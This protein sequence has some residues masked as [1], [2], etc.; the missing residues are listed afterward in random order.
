MKKYF[1]QDLVEE[2]VRWI[3]SQFIQKD[4]KKVLSDNN[5]DAES[6]RKVDAIP[7]DPKY[8]DTVQDL[9]DYV[10]LQNLQEGYATKEELK[11]IDIS[12]QLKEYQKTE[13]RGV[14]GGYASLGLDGKVPKSQLPE[15]KDTITSIGGKTGVISKED[16]VKLGIPAQDT[17]YS[18]ANGSVQGLSTND[19]STLEKTKLQNIETKAQV[20]KIETIKRNGSIISASEDKSVNIEVPTK[21]SQLS[22]D[23]GF[24]T[25]REVQEAIQQAKSFGYKF[26]QHLPEEGEDN[27]IYAVQAEKGEGQNL[28]KEYYWVAETR[29]WEEFGSFKA[30]LDTS[31]FLSEENFQA[32]SSEELQEILQQ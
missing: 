22:N 12:E 6:K 3:K 11:R 29:T 18:L 17:K 16:I 7:E 30:D 5:Y 1:P 2:L 19:Y 23:S 28:K 14:S 10:K 26:V 15:D 8:T 32:M 21:I 31:S 25:K 13:A 9:S 24:Q 20:N 27:V 4:G